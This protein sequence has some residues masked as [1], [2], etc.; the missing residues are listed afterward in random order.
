VRRHHHSICGLLAALT[1]LSISSEAQAW[2]DVGHK[3]I[4]E[5]AFKLAQPRTQDQIQKLIAI[6]TEYR[7]FA[8]SCIFADHWPAPGSEDTRLRCSMEQK[9]GHG[10]AEV[11]AGVQA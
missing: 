4:C 6:D 1:L 8:D 10:E 11:Y 5:I 7:T 9:A 3:I 2:G